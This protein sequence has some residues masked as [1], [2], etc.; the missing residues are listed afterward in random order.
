[1]IKLLLDLLFIFLLAINLWIG[2]KAFVEINISF[3]NEFYGKPYLKRKMN[4]EEKYPKE[5]VDEV[6]KNQD[7]YDNIYFDNE[8]DD[9]DEDSQKNNKGNRRDG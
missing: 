3:W 7:Q 4:F 5:L 9:H 8:T 2:A 1:M 6:M